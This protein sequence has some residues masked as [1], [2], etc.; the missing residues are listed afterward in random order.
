[1]IKKYASST[2]ILMKIINFTHMKYLYCKI[3]LLVTLTLFFVLIISCQNKSGNKPDKP[4]ILIILADDMGYSDLGCM[5]SEIETPNL[6]M[7][8]DNG[9]LFTNCYNTSRC[10]PSRASLL[11]GLYPHSTG[12][13]HLTDNLGYPSYQGY[14]NDK[15]VT[16]AEMLQIA[17]YRTIMSGKWHIGDKREH[18]P[19]RRGF[20]HFFGIPKG[21]GLYFYPSRFIDR[22]I[23]RNSELVKPDSATF[24]STDDFTTEAINFIDKTK[25]SGQ[26]FFLYLAYI[27]P[28]YPLQAWPKDIARYKDRY[29]T[30]Y[31]VIRQNRFRRQQE[32]GIVSPELK[33]SPPEYKNWS[34]VNAKEE[35][36]KMAVYAAMVDR[37]DQNIGKLISYL[38][39]AGELKNTIIFFLSDNGACAENV[40]RSPYAETGTVQ[41]FVS[42]GENWANVSNTPYRKYKSQEHEG[43]IIT[44]LIVHWPEGIKQNSRKVTDVVHIIDIVPTCLEIAE[45]EYPAEYKGNTILPAEGISFL[46]VLRNEKI[47]ERRNLYWEHQ[48][49]KAIRMNDKKLVKLNN[50]EWELYSLDNDPTELVNLAVKKPALK[51][52]LENLW[53]EWAVRCNI[54]DWPVK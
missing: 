31:E 19:D 48:G 45:A 47:E 27:A 3:I 39:S 11:T 1:M 44:P 41:S 13:G 46:P 4:N 26:P 30:G 36:Y 20:E 5:G 40:N 18:W 8:A 28:H 43:G 23:Y 34:E 50:R 2:M 21:G 54:R 38:E 6:D 52:S 35:S 42:Y 17:G 22:P 49:N 25:F 29:N 33:L 9:L 7:L 51:D 14:L 16:L 10:S 12:V 53:N 24:Y 32:L 15:C 37:M